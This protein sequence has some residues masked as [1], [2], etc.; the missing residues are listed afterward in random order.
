[1]VQEPS[2]SELIDVI[3]SF[4]ETMT[5]IAR[6]QQQQAQLTATAHAAQRRVT[7][8][9]NAKGIVIE[10][11]FTEDI[12][13]L[14]PQELATAVTA[15]AQDAAK[16]VDGKT[17]E[18]IDGLQAEQARLPKMSDFLEGLPDFEKM[19]PQPPEVSL[20]PPSRRRDG[21]ADEVDEKAPKPMKFDNVVPVDHEQSNRNGVAR[22]GW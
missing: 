20:A 18:I 15:A 2:R 16:Q 11:R 9:V 21:I 4:Q 8:V 22:S 3:E 12:T 19:V 7:V 1:M 14:T 10:T 17:K 13:E 5:S 6:A